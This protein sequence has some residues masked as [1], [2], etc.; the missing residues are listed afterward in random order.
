MAGKDVIAMFGGE[1]GYGVMSAGMMLAKA[2][3]RN[4]LQ[5]MVVN[6]YPS[7]I[8][9]GLNNCLV[10]FSKANL[11]SYEES[12]DVLGAISQQAYELNIAK[13]KPGGLVF[14]DIS[15]K[16]ENIAVPEGVRRVPVRLIQAGTGD[17][18]KIMANSAV[19]AAFCAL[20][21]FPVE[22]VKSVII[23]DFTDPAVQSKNLEI[24][25]Q[26]WQSVKKLQPTEKMEFPFK[27][28]PSPR[29][30]MLLTGNDA[31]AMGAIAAGCRFAAGYPMTPATSV[32]VYLADHAVQYGI[33]F[34]QAED[35]IAAVNMLIGAGFAGVR[36]WGR[37]A[38][39]GLPDD[40]GS[41]ICGDCR[42]SLVMVM[43][44]RADPRPV[45]RRGQCRRI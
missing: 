10:R 2:A 27:L 32:L 3:V 24:F 25:E 23:A 17:A 16:V 35:E 4:S 39:E 13:V 28:A 6:E 5:A 29:N 36:R 7:L 45:C 31:I 34:K 44:Q 1:A 15:V 38:A 22:M 41:R 8:K 18:A 26:T 20:T 11:T 40:R 43:A 19:M 12:V 33:V 21:G 30:R 14:H 42:S 37:P 9:G